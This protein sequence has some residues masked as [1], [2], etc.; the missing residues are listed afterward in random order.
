MVFIT[1]DLSNF[2]SKSVMILARKLRC[3]YTKDI[4]TRQ[5]LWTSFLKDRIEYLNEEV[6]I[7]SWATSLESVSAQYLQA[8]GQFSFRKGQS[9][10]DWQ[11]DSRILSIF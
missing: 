4:D 2:T 11:C 10:T 1:N 7:K 9:P 8:R 3:I 5:D 6:S